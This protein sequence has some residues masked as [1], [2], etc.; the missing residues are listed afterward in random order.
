MSQNV[1]HVELNAGFTFALSSARTRN[2]MRGVSLV[3]ASGEQ[4]IRT[5]RRG[6]F[7]L[8]DRS[9]GRSQFVLSNYVTFGISRPFYKAPLRDLK[10]E[11][12]SAG[13][14]NPL[15]QI[16]AEAQLSA[17]DIRDIASIDQV[18]GDPDR[19]ILNV[20]SS[21]CRKG[22]P[23]RWR[24]AKQPFSAHLKVSPANKT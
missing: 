11:V 18:I 10:S 15:P 13:G 22:K 23:S 1:N 20:T 6:L 9:P 12:S 24:V 16:L 17:L 19:Y 8:P 14:V 7:F 3:S 5:Y 21:T 2:S 4:P